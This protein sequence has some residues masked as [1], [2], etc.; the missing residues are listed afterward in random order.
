ML[1]ISDLYKNYFPCYT[2]KYV[3]HLQ[4]LLKTLSY[5]FNLPTIS[6]E[7]NATVSVWMLKVYS[8]STRKYVGK[9]QMSK[10]M[11]FAVLRKS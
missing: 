1:N 4:V 6:V 8:S 5:M 7:F 3:Q 9:C 2:Y 11:K 10:Y